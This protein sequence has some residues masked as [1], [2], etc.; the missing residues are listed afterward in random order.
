MM[1]GGGGVICKTF[2]TLAFQLPSKRKFQ[3]VAWSGGLSSHPPKNPPLLCT[4]HITQY[5]TP[6]SNTGMSQWKHPAILIVAYY[7]VSSTYKLQKYLEINSMCTTY[8]L[9]E[10]T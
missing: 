1:E 10:N 8:Y 7:Q 3:K 2:A 5:S 9:Q 4:Q 6:S